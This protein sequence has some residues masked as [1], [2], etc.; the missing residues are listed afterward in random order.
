MRSGGVLVATILIQ[1]QEPQS[2]QDLKPCRVA[3]CGR[4]VVEIWLPFNPSF[5]NLESLVSSCENPSGIWRGLTR[6]HEVTK[7]AE[8]EPSPGTRRVVGEDYTS[9]PW[10]WLSFA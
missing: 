8:G 9:F 2:T 10:S 7:R 6:R 1:P 3:D 4:L 5:T